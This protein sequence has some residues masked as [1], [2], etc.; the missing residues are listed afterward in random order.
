LK[1]PV[2]HLGEGAPA[3]IVLIDPKEERK[4]TAFSSRSQNSPFLGW[5]LHGFPQ[6]VLVDGRVVLR[7]GALKTV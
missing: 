5:T 3:D 2:G 1:L 4:L 7:R 6:A